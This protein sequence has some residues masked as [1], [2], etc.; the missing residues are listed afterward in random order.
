MC[1]GRF[2]STWLLLAELGGS[3]NG[4]A[5]ATFGLGGTGRWL[6]EGSAELEAASPVRKVGAAL[7][8]EFGSVLLSSGGAGGG[9]GGGGGGGSIA[10][11]VW[12][13][14]DRSRFIKKLQYTN[15]SS[16]ELEH[17]LFGIS[18]CNEPANE[19][20]LTCSLLYSHAE[21][22]VPISPSC[23]DTPEACGRN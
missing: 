10:H 17:D 16:T 2:A 21:P 13:G 6:A 8:H 4:L 19:H 20:T 5:S 1:F 23:L 11:R 9:G 3:S 12:G 14:C 7:L 22:A 15:V 18:S